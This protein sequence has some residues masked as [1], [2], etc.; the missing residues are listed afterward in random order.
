MANLMLEAD[1]GKATFEEVIRP[2][3]PMRDTSTYRPISNLVLLN[4]LKNVADMQG[5]ELKNPEYGLARKGQRMFGVFEVEGHDHLNGQ[6]K[7]MMGVRN[8]F[9]ELFQQAYVLAVRCLFA[10]T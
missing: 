1:S 9:D 2:V 6:V 5:L 3:V 4:M 7:M 10:V 8:A